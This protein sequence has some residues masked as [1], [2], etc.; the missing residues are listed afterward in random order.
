[1]AVL[2]VD[3]STP[4]TTG[5]RDDAGILMAAWRPPHQ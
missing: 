5:L 1:M 4:H 3:A 2:S